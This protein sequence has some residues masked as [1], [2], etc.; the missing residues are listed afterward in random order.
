M[1]EAQIIELVIA[2]LNI[3]ASHQNAKAK[4]EEELEAEI[5]KT[6]EAFKTKNPK[7]LPNL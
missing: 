6:F 7:F 3:I 1:T 5:A 4:T 2:L